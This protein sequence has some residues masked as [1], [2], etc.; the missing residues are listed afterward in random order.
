MTIGLSLAK[1]M[2]GVS[3]P[4]HGLFPFFRLKIA[5]NDA[6][7]QMT[8]EKKFL[9]TKN[10]KNYAKGC[11]ARHCTP[12]VAKNMAAPASVSPIHAKT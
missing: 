7:T 2:T 9:E 10:K 11:H 12:L 6:V 4:R 1:T 8:A 3:Y 5:G